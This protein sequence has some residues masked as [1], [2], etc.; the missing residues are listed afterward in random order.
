LT[1]LTQDKQFQ[2]GKLRKKLAAWKQAN[3]NEQLGVCWQ[4][5]IDDTRIKLKA[6]YPRFQ[7]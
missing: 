1:K 5:K 3:N 7:L 6:L 4:F 2:I